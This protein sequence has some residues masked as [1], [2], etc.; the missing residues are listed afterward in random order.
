MKAIEL[1]N[2][3][4]SYQ[5]DDFVL[6]DLNMNVPKGSIYGFLG[7][8]GEGKST[9]L[10]LILSLLK[11]KSA[12]VIN[13]M[14]KD[15]KQQYPSY[16]SHLGSLIE[17]AS[18]YAHLSALENLKIWSNYVNCPK[19]RLEEVLEIVG[20][21]NANKKKAGAFSTGM[22]QRLGIAIALLNDPD[23]LIL[24]EPTNGLDPIGVN[25]LRALLFRLKAQGKTIVLSSHILAEVEKIVD[26]VGI[27]KSGNLVFEGSLNQLRESTLLNQWV[28]VKLENPKAAMEILKQHYEVQ[29]LDEGLQVFVPSKNEINQ[30]LALLLQHDF[31]IYEVLQPKNDLDSIFMRLTK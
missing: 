14:G 22:K 17:N 29:L 15:V 19:V 23:I 3:H 25:D 30:L 8:N 11:N 31:Q 10:K 12:G 27:L 4:F 1:N 21:A 9:T 18:I 28:T 16:L 6:K 13:V 26:H 24:D 2:I 7:P 5:K 20:L